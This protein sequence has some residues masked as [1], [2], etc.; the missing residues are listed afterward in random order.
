ME[1]RRRLRRGLASVLKTGATPIFFIFTPEI[2]HF[3]PYCIPA[4][5]KGFEPVLILNSVSASDEQWLREIH[6]TRLLISLK[7]SLTGNSNSL[8]AHGDVLNN[9]FATL[10]TS[11]CVQDP[12]CFV[13]HPSFWDQVS[14]DTKSDMAGGPFTQ[15]PTHHDHVLPD[16]FFLMLNSRLFRS[17]RDRY[18]ISAGTE[19]HLKPAATERIQELGYGQGQFP[20]QFKPYFDTLQAY[21]LL[22]LAEGYRFNK[23]P[24]VGETIFHIGGTSYLHSSDYD[25]SHWDYWPLSV[26]YFNLRLLELEAGER[27]RGRFKTILDRYGSA[28]ELL[29]S[30][31][32][33]L[34]THR[35]SEMQKFLA[36]LVD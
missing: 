11:F 10:S 22:A 9:L 28:N 6:P 13:T 12:D 8:L 7:V 36:L 25:L 5:A 24:G 32:E 14:L 35:F 19:S 15:K 33:F 4:N 2:V 16:T 26:I 17:L 1:N 21:W 20:Q 31:P 30:Y 34:G 18:Q 23:F 27:F 29:A 3:A